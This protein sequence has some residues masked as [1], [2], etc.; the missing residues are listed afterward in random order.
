MPFIYFNNLLTLQVVVIRNKRVVS[1]LKVHYEP[2]GA[3]VHPG[4]TEVAL[5]AK[6]VSV[7]TISFKV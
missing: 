3:S 4:G 5:G 6:N 2:C 1:R 7:K